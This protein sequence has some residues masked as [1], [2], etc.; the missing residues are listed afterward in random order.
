MF[1]RQEDEVADVVSRGSLSM[2]VGCSNV[3]VKGLLNLEFEVLVK[4]LDSSNGD[5]AGSRRWRCDGN[6][7]GRVETFIGKERRDSGAR[8][9]SIVVGKFSKRKVLGPIVLIV[10]DELATV[11]F[12]DLIDAFGLT[13]G[14]WMIR[15]G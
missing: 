11:G 2:R 8:V 10:V 3:F 1:H 13:V 9:S 4:V 7:E 14:F 12:D 15:R 6:V 5:A